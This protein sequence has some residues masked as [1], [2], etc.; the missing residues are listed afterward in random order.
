VSSE[1]IADLR[2]EVD[3][4]LARLESRIREL[5][6]LLTD[7][8]APST[9]PRFGFPGLRPLPRPQLR[10]VRRPP[11]ERLEI[12]EEPERGDGG[13]KFERGLD[14]PVAANWSR[15]MLVVTG[16]STLLLFLLVQLFC[17]SPSGKPRQLRR[18][19]RA[20]PAGAAA[21]APQALPPG[22]LLVT[23]STE[24]EGTEPMGTTPR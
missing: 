6:D 5:E 4:R 18:E 24:P 11:L 23:P 7:A 1:E 2:R 16:A 12:G 21:P 10:S 20:V 15:P 9:R 14:V 22:T 3:R 17:A 19:P 13:P 8:S